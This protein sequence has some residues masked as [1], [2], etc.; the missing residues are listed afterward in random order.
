MKHVD[1]H[2]AE[3]GLFMHR[4]TYYRKYVTHYYIIIVLGFLNR[5]H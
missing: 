5:Q 3:I 4:S 2:Q 1:M